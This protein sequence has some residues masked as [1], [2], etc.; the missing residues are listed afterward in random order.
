M[1]KYLSDMFSIVIVW[2]M[3]LILWPGF[4][5]EFET[6]SLDVMFF[7]STLIKLWLSVASYQHSLTQ[8]SFSD[9]LI[10]L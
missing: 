1:L 6:T 3:I 4:L 9:D 2:D 7:Y 5:S 10:K 8:K